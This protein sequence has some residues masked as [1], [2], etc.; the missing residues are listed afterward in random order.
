M[1]TLESR[2]IMS[3]NF[4]RLCFPKF[5][6]TKFMR[7]TLTTTSHMRPRARDHHTSSTLIG[8]K[9]GAGPSSL[10]ATLE[11]P[12]EYVNARWICSLPGFLH[13]IEWIM[14]HGHLD[15]FQ[16][17]SLAGRP[18]TKPLGD[19][20]TLSTHNH[21]FILFHDVWGPVWI[22]IHWN[23]IW[24]KAQSHMFYNHHKATPGPSLIR[25]RN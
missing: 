24:L 10:H 16:K 17:P 21:W 20:G 18:N 7:V 23:S 11:G 8:E 2:S 22:K 9:G 6:L 25:C 14:F 12:T 3:K 5:Q 15:C 4:P 13:D 19:H 1:G